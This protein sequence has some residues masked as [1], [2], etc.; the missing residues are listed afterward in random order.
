MKYVHRHGARQPESGVSAFVHHGR[1]GQSG[2][3]GNQS[4]V[5]G[6]LGVPP[7]AFDPEPEGKRNSEDEDEGDE[8]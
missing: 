6:E 4:A 3:N 2:G 1:A 5:L 8:E 7:P